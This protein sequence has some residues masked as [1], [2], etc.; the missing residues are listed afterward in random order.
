MRNAYSLERGFGE[1]RELKISEDSPLAGKKIL[2][3]VLPERC[4]I[5]TLLRGDMVI[6]APVNEIITDGDLC[7]I[8]VTPA[9]IRKMEQILVTNS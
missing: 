7:I 8:Y 6:Y 2:E 4:W 5:A 1:I 9:S 3:I